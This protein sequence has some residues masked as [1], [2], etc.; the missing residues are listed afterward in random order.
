MAD[1]RPAPDRHHTAMGP[2]VG[3]PGSTRGPKAM[4]VRK[5]GDIGV[6]RRDPACTILDTGRRRATFRPVAAMEPRGLQYVALE[7]TSHASPAAPSSRGPASASLGLSY[8]A[9]LAAG[10]W[11][12]PSQP[13]SRPFRHALLSREPDRGPLGRRALG[14]AGRQRLNRDIT[15]RDGRA[16]GD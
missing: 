5:L 9:S 7:R 3:F 8:P 1:L 16:P 14:Q 10:R 11:A 4:P 13:P 6:N 2:A 12:H 15:S